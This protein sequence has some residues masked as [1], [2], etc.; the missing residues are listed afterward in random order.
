M[1]KF[2]IVIVMWF[3]TPV[4]HV[5]AIEVDSYNGKPLDFKSI[6]ECFIHIGNNYESLR[7]FGKERFPQSIGL[8]E[9]LCARLG[10]SI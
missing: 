9:I 2:V 6:E 3:T 8:K 1:S 7:S 4:V 10:K 5:D